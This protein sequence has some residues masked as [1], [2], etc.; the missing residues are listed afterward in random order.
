MHIRSEAADQLHLLLNAR[1]RV[2]RL[3]KDLEAH[4]RGALKVHGIRL[5]SISQRRRRA[6]FRGQ[7]ALAAEH[8]PFLAVIAD[9]FIPLHETLC[10]VA[11]DLDDELRAIAKESPLARR[12]MTVPGVGVMVSLG[13]IATVDHADRFSAP[14]S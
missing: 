10:A 13:F 6:E 11:E 14:K 4:V 8:D 9:S 2:V 5:T 7:L 1:E 12:L 3:R